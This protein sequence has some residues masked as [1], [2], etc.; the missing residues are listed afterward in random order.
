MR[1]SKWLIALLMIGCSGPSASDEAMQRAIEA[2]I[3]P[4]PYNG[5]PLPLLEEAVETWGG[6]PRQL[7]IQIRSAVESLREDGV[8]TS[9]SEVLDAL[10]QLKHRGV[11]RVPTTNMFNFENNYGYWRKTGSTHAQSIDR[12]IDHHKF[13]VYPSVAQ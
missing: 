3:P 1:A 11:M 2:R 6:T 10:L 7:T 9:S 5:L 12:L 4:D 8:P 13:D